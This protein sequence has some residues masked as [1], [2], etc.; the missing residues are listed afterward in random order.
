MHNYGIKFPMKIFLA[1]GVGR[2]V[3]LLS[4]TYVHFDA[5]K[6]SFQKIFYYIQISKYSSHPGLEQFSTDTIVG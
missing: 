2:A 3:T 1:M 4:A 5:N 6:Y